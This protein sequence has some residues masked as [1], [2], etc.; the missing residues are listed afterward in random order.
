MVAP[1]VAHEIATSVP[2]TTS[3]AATENVGVATVSRPDAFRIST[4]VIW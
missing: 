3:P 4:G 1:S 2:A